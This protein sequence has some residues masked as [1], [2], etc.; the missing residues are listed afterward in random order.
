MPPLHKVVSVIRLTLAEDLEVSL[1]MLS[2]FLSNGPSA[3]Q[4]CYVTYGELDKDSLKMAHPR[5]RTKVFQLGPK[6]PLPHWVPVHTGDS[7]GA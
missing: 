3:Q 5:T 7:D 1:E 2:Q 6:L 4:S